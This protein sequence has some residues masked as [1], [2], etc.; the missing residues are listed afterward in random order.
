M[1]KIQA[2]MKM[3]VLE[4]HRTK[5]VDPK[6]VQELHEKSIRKGDRKIQDNFTIYET[7]K[8]SLWETPRTTIC[9]FKMI[10]LYFRKNEV[11]KPKTLK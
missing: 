3:Q 5:N 9:L 1:T 8:T 6:I 4:L 10:L 2:K 11:I 7:F